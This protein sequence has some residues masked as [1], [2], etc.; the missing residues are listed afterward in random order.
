MVP[1]AFRS[2]VCK[3]KDLEHDQLPLVH[4]KELLADEAPPRVGERDRA[5]HSD[6]AAECAHPARLDSPALLGRCRP[7]TCR[8]N[9][10]PLSRWSLPALPSS[11]ATPALQSK[12]THPVTPGG[13]GSPGHVKSDGRDRAAAFTTR[14]VTLPR[15][16]M[17]RAL[18][19]LGGLFLLPLVLLAVRPA[20]PA[21]ESAAAG[22]AAAGP[23]VGIVFDVGGRGDKSFNDGA[24][25]GAERAGAQ[26]R[27]ERTLRRAGR[28]LGP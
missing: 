23:R 26:A 24:W 7:S 11:S 14:H 18:A 27:G 2:P 16:P 9:V 19:C 4:A 22:K 12:A 6:N 21:V 20:G 8:P 10:R 3:S 17:K 1:L 15:V 13:E 25:N 28:R 5:L